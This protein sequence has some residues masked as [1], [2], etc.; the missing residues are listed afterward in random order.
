MPEENAK[1]TV[2]EYVAQLKLKVPAAEHGAL[3]SR[4]E[5]LLNDPNADE[6]DVMTVLGQE[7]DPPK[8][9]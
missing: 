5:E 8:A 7:F 2:D 3:E 1:S 4:V 6:N 9:S